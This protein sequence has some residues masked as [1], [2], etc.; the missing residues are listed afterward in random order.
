MNNISKYSQASRVDLSLMEEDGKIKL[1]IQDNGNGF[2]P[3]T[4]RKGMGLSTMR[5]RAELSGG[6]FELESAV[7]KGTVVRAEWNV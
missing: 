6:S 5:E 7:G 4:V 3:N 2:D 1:T